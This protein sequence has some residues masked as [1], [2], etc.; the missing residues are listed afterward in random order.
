MG[1]IVRRECAESIRT[2][3]R[4]AMPECRLDAP[5]SMFRFAA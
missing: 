5:M 2:E 4:L 1:K 3:A